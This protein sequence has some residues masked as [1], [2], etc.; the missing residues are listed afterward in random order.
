MYSPEIMILMRITGDNLRFKSA[1][2]TPLSELVILVVAREWSQ[3]FE[4]YVINPLRFKWALERPP[5]KL[6]LKDAGHK[7]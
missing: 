5:R 4:W 1:I 7:I 3:D 6:L 2:G